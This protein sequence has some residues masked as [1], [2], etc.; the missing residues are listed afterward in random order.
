MGESLVDPTGSKRTVCG[1]PMVAGREKRDSQLA[2]I[3][4]SRFVLVEHDKV[5]WD[6]LRTKGDG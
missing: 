2:R 5:I 4:Q 6:P 1:I 3:F